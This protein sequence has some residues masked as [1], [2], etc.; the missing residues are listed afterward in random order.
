MGGKILEF[1]GE[2][3]YNEGITAGE[4]AALVGLVYDGLLAE[5]RA[6]E[7]A[8]KKYGVP[9]KKFKKMLEEYHPDDERMQG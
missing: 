8:E 7:R 2:K 4:V 5:D 3:L 9:A 1:T 6:M